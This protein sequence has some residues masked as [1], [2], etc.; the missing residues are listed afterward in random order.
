MR[1]TRL[2]FALLLAAIAPAMLAGTIRTI[3]FESPTPY[4]EPWH[5]NWERYFG[6]EATFDYGIRRGPLEGYTT[7][8]MY[9]GGPGWCG[10]C[11]YD[12]I[13]IRF[14]K[15]V[16][17]IHF[18]LYNWFDYYNGPI[19]WDTR[20][21]F[22]GPP[23]SHM[24]I[25]PLMNSQEGRVITVPG[26]HIR[27][28][29]IDTNWGVGLDDFTFEVEDDNAVQTFARF[30]TPGTS[31]ILY[32]TDTQG[33]VTLNVPLGSLVSIGIQ[34]KQGFLD[35][36][37]SIPAVY[38]TGVASPEPAKLAIP[39]A[40]VMPLV[41]TMYDSRLV[42]PLE[43][44]PDATS[45]RF[46]AAHLGTA[47]VTITPTFSATLPTK[48][49]NVHVIKPTLLGV[50]QNSF[51]DYIIN[52]AHNTGLPPQY[53]KGQIRQEADAA[54]INPGNWRYEPCGADLSYVSAGAQ[55]AAT[56]QQYIDYRLDD[57]I[58]V[59]IFPYIGDELDPRSRFFIV[60]PAPDGS[61]VDRHITD[62]DRNVTALEIWDDNNKNPN[63]KH[64][65]FDKGCR[66]S[67]L[68]LINAPQSTVLN[69]TAQTVTGASYGMLQ[70]MWEEAI[71]NDLWAGIIDP[72]AAFFSK[73]PKYLF[74]RPEYIN[75]GGGSVQVGANKTVRTFMGKANTSPNFD[76]F[77]AYEKHLNSAIRWYNHAWFDDSSGTKKY[78]GDVV[79]D[80]S[81]L[82]A[83]NIVT[84]VFQ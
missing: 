3:D 41:R 68:A 9:W 49:V 57:H 31:P 25:S 38:A 50:T 5:H 21:I 15:P 4:A 19:R 71:Q 6:S 53:L 76:T 45:Q 83:P 59:T 14:S 79:I 58:N 11:L 56:K 29:D 47:T 34:Q 30:E 77:A 36:V 73:K 84:P 42:L 70:V 2:W 63:H 55:Y 75:I 62:D 82:Y 67:M 65:N 39:T 74:D 16:K 37:L 64:W 24:T 7:S 1:Q 54:L 78:Y 26:E 80:R 12:P 81:R 52:V 23:L 46:L 28:L 48:K 72:P 60:R 18:T 69:F 43:V 27:Y 61:I 66:D 8:T 33:D 13:E 10:N 40:T 22:S 32:A 20:E 44:A 51:D 17:N 35:P